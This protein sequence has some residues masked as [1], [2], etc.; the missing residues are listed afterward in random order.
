[1]C[2]KKRFLAR[3][4]ETPKGVSSLLDTIGNYFDLHQTGE[5]LGQF[6]F[7]AKKTCYFLPSNL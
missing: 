2:I 5:S 6:S 7:K 4:K 1:M 3:K